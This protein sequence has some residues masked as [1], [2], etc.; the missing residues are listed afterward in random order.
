MGGA[1]QTALEIA[2]DLAVSFGEEN[3]QVFTL[4]NSQDS[5]C[6]ITDN[7]KVTRIFS[8]TFRKS[9][10][11]SLTRKIIEKFRILLDTE[12]KKVVTR[13][14]LYFNPDVVILH[15]IDRLGLNF[16]SYFRSTSKVPIVRMQHDLGDTCIY[17][18]RMRKNFGKN[19]IKTCA[20]C[21]MKE[22]LMR[23]ESKHYN[24]MLSVSQF[25]DSTLSKLR[26]KPQSANFGYPVGGNSRFEMGHYSFD[27]VSVLRLG[28]V[29]RVVP[30]KGIETILNSLSILNSDFGKI[31]S[32]KICGTGNLRYI[33]RLGDLANKLSVKLDFLGYQHAPFNFLIGKVD[34]VVVPSKWQ[35]PLGR[36]PLEAFG[37]GFPCFVSGIG[38]LLESRN[39]LVGPIVY[40]E[41][42][43][44]HDLAVKLA[45]ALDLGI[46]IT[47]PKASAPSLYFILERYLRSIQMD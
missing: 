18:T 9:I 21:R 38:G 3:L 34:A 40:F 8:P 41:P 12:T 35:E 6:D 15:N 26:F 36:V 33:K 4:S 16:S 42:A 1:E 14:I 37:H 30:E 47:Q 13:E 44:A 5:F 10:N 23:N 22:N 32:L 17:R 28:F 7:L 46:P 19:C 24:L 27:N 29:G 20:S 45:T 11:I 43:N 2:K 31:G 25:V 39:F